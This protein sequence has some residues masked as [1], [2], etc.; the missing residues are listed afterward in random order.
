MGN[1]FGPGCSGERDVGRASERVCG[2]RCVRRPC[3]T[4]AGR[5]PRAEVP[6]TVAANGLDDEQVLAA[7]RV[8]IGGLEDVV[9]R[10]RN[11]NDWCAHAVGEGANGRLRAVE[12]TVVIGREQVAVGRVANDPHV[13]LHTT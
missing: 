12:V 9:L 5:A 13:N 6:S 3:A 8:D 1:I 10:A 4:E 2:G 7:D 11:C